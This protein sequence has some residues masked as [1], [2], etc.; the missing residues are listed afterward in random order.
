[1]GT[2]DNGRDWLFSEKEIQNSASRREGCSLEE[3]NVLR[4]KSI[5]FLFELA[6]ILD[7]KIIAAA[8]ASVYFHRYF[9]SH[10]FKSHNR[11]YVASVCLFLASKNEDQFKTIERVIVAC[12]FLRERGKDGMNEDIKVL[13][14]EYNKVY[15]TTYHYMDEKKEKKIFNDKINTLKQEFIT[16]EKSLLIS[17]R[18]DMHVTHP[19]VACSNHLQKIKGVY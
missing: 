5:W 4:A 16:I 13:Q 14:H 18:F 11:F 9:L 3:E 8:T 17:L 15:H 6:K 1:M 12:N 2:K 7:A 19:H 10:S